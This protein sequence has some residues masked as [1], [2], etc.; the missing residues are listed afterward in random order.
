M[1]QPLKPS[2]FTDYPWD[3][4]K[5]QAEYEIVAQNIMKIKKR[6]G[7]EWT[8]LSWEQYKEERLKDAHFTGEEYGLFNEVIEYCESPEAAAKFSKAWIK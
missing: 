6:L 4:V 2:D 3:S 8:K 5:Q 1:K 7:N